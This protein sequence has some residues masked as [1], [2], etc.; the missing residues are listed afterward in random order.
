MYADMLIHAATG[1]IFQQRQSAAIGLLR[2]IY[3]YLEKYSST[4]EVPYCTS[5]MENERVNCDKNTL[6]NLKMHLTSCGFVPKGKTLSTTPDDDT[7]L[8]MC[9]GLSLHNLARYLKLNDFNRSRNP[10]HNNCGYTPPLRID[11]DNFLL[12]VDELKLSE[13]P[14]CLRGAHQQSCLGPL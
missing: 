8:A 9:S 11:V 6:I 14:P 3:S 7:L 4:P 13:F 5:V 2:L 10:H 1:A 12:I